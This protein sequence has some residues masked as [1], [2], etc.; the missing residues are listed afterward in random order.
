MA[1]LRIAKDSK[2]SFILESV[3]A[4]ENIAR[5]S[6]IG[7]GK[8]QMFVNILRDSNRIEDPFK[9]VRTGPGT[10][11]EGDPM[12]HLQKELGMYRYV[13]LPEIPCFTGPSLS[14]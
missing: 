10:E 7:S 13:K 5:Y 8:L 11:L 2:Y 1:Y 4:G 6:F 12:V 14:S 9:V 3:L